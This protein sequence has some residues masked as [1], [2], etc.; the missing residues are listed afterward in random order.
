MEGDMV[1]IKLDENRIVKIKL[2]KGQIGI[3]HAILSA[4]LSSLLVDIGDVGEE[5]VIPPEIFDKIEPILDRWVEEVLPNILV[6]CK[7]DD[8]YGEDIL[9]IFT[10]L[11]RISGERQQYFQTSRG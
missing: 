4:K 11:V 9:N 6:D 8:L 5:I 3:K 1:E 7:I 10:E 2:P